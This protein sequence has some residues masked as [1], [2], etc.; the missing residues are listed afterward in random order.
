MTK[1]SGK[2]TH[3]VQGEY[4]FIKT[5]AGDIE[6]EKAVFGSWCVIEDK[7]SQFQ[8]FAKS[9]EYCIEGIRKFYAQDLGREN[10]NAKFVLYTRQGEIL[11]Y[12]DTPIYMIVKY[13]DPKTGEITL[14]QVRDFGLKFELMN[15]DELEVVEKVHYS[16]NT[17]EEALERWS[18]KLG[19]P[20][21]K[22][23]FTTSD[24]ET[25]KETL[26]KIMNVEKDRII[27]KSF[28]NI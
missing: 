2:S 19:L 22:F 11:E 14:T 23:N 28:R 1:E 7:K 10:G 20:I 26:S 13:H 18:E 21:Y 9:F 25:E 12:S 4:F 5:V 27:W 17:L 6:C 3:Q 8:V 15:E 24:V 16:E